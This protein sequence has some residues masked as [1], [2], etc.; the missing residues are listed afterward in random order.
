MIRS[1]KF[2]TIGSIVSMALMFLTLMFGFIEDAYH[3]SS[4]SYWYSSGHYWT[5]FADYV[6]EVYWPLFAFAMI[7][8]AFGIV[9]IALYNKRIKAINIV[10]LILTNVVY[11]YGM[12]AAFVA[13]DYENVTFAIFMLLAGVCVAY[14]FHLVVEIFALIA[15]RYKVIDNQLS[16]VPQHPICAT[17]VASAE[18]TVNQNA[19][20]MLKQLKALYDADVLT[21]EEYKAKRQQYVSKI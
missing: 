13:I 18:S 17:Q 12:I 11:M 9:A 2:F 6:G 20:E 21:E 19:I 14:P 7:Y 8:I 16:N 4:G 15:Q 5:S 1:K 10:N 3:Y